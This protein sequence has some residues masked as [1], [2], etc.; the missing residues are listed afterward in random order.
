MKNKL[1]T[2]P[3]IGRLLCR[4]GFKNNYL[5]SIYDYYVIKTIERSI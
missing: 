4:I 5:N 3:K 2:M 1:L